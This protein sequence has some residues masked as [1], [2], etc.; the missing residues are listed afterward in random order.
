MN[1]EKKL[2]IGIDIDDTLVDFIS[3]YL[4]FYEWKFERKINFEE[5]SDIY[6]REPFGNTGKEI[7]DL[8]EEYHK[9]EFYKEIQLLEFAKDILEGLFDF[10]QIFFITSRR[11]SHEESTR[12]FLAKHFSEKNY[13]VYFSGDIYSGRKLKKEICADLSLD[14]MIEDNPL[15][16]KDCASAGI[17][18][19]LLDKPWNQNVEHEN[20]IRVKS[21][22]EI[23]EE[24]EKFRK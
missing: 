13:G 20:I 19:L 2:K 6:L 8:L 1:E 22:K 14:F 11:P 10:A 9:T 15:F 17:K 5:V 4:Q 3:T 16:S 7:R 23:L 18:V 24:I 12:N 21:W